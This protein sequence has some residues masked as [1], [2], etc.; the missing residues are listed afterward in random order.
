[1]KERSQ[2]QSTSQSG[3]GFQGA[4]KLWHWKKKMIKQLNLFQV[5]IYN[6][7]RQF[8]DLDLT[9]SGTMLASLDYYMYLRTYIKLQSDI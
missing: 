7:I 1:M 2:Q 6:R 4:D 9:F 5:N 3:V 8:N